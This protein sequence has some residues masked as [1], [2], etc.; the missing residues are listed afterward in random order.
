MRILTLPVGDLQTNCYL[1]FGDHRDDAVI[2]DPGGEGDKI[3]EALAGRAP[4]A[5]LLTHGHFDHTGALYDFAS[6]PIYIHKLDSVMLSDTYYRFDDQSGSLNPRPQATHFLQEGQTLELAGIKIEVLH[7]PGH[8][9]GSVCFKMGTELLT[10]DTLF[11]GDYGRTDL[12]GGSP[13]QMRA[14]LRRLF[15]LHGCHVL[16]GH[17]P[18][19]WI[20]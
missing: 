13:A 16:P 18:D 3:R 11:K 20:K 6:L 1:L 2:V 12:P 17:G 5:V 7:T 15:T 8:T 9:P 14:S 10:G 19:D 4:A